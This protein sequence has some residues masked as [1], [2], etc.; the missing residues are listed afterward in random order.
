VSLVTQKNLQPSHLFV[1]PVTSGVSAKKVFVP[2]FTKINVA[3]FM[4]FVQL[5]GAV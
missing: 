4:V 3:I 2:K 5:K 1:L